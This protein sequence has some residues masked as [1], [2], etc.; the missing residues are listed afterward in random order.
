MSRKKS[1]PEYKVEE[2]D[3]RIK[4]KIIC[5]KDIIWNI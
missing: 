1:T 3:L 2:T 5:G 4:G